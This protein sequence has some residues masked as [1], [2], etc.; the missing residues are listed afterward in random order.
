[1]SSSNVLNRWLLTHLKTAELVG[2][3]MRICSFSVVSW[4][5]QGSPF[6]LVWV[7]NTLDAM[8]LSWCAILRRDVAY[9]LLNLFWI[10][11]GVVG[12]LRAAG[13]L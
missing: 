9:S 1:M 6:L 7:V 4:L 12:V 11:V 3:A 2:V 10:A 5:G 13:I 8:L